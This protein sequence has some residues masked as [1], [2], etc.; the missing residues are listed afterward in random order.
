MKEVVILG[1]GL[2]G[3]AAG[4]YLNKKWGSQIN[5]TLLEKSDRVG[6]WIRT[7]HQNGFLFEQGPHGFRPTG[8]GRAT[9]DLVQDLGLKSKLI[10]ANPSAKKRYLMLDGSLHRFSLKLLLKH[11]FLQGCFRDWKTPPSS[12]EDETI[13]HFF[14]RRFNAS[15]TETFVDSI[16][17]GIYGG[18]MTKLS[19]RSC[20]PAFWKWEKQKGSLI[21]GFL[22]APKE[23]SVPLYSF[24]EGMELLPKTLAAQLPATIL[25]STPVKMIEKREKNFMVHL[26]HETIKADYLVSALPSFALAQI[27][28]PL[29]PLLD[30]PFV[31]LSIVH[32]GWHANV[33]KKQG[34]GFLVPSKEK[35]ALLGMI[36]DSSVFPSQNRGKQTR[37][38]L[39]ISGSYSHHDLVTMARQYIDSHLQISKPPD[40]VLTTVANNAIAQYPI[41]HHLHLQKLKEAL[42]E[43]MTLLG[44]SFYGV[45]VNDC[46][47]SSQ[48]IYNRLNLKMV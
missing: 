23:K 37:L 8:K 2:S 26:D 30:I 48:A 12:E 38:T 28:S 27:F 41:N 18:D 45:G 6:G 16:V 7:I 47:A 11:G 4:W 33:L 13:A 44:N 20:F 42:P 34:F 21:R 35:Q 24:Q 5:I 43:G 17:K 19:C 10:A 46:I 1:A 39:M 29:K 15:F 40:E 31:T 9:L 32:L 22:A 3:L 14:E 25:L 36:W